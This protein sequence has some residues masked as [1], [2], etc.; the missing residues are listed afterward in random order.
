MKRQEVDMSK[1]SPMM[2]HYLEIK[3]K[4]PDTII[5]YRLGDFYEMF[6][7][8]A[9]L[10]SHELELTLTGRN[11]GLE[12]RVPM[13]GIPYHAYSSY[14][15]KLINRGYKVAICEQLEDPK[16]AKG[17]VDRDVIQVITRG[18]LMDNL[19][20]EKDNNYLA[21][22]YDYGY[23]YSLTYADISTWSTVK[24]RVLIRVLKKLLLM[25]LLIE[26]LFIILKRNIIF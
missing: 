20:S 3:E 11:A 1:V 19:V 26:R 18:T 9:E 8:D 14:V 15:T 5:F 25:I 10:V 21:S 24:E 23:S 22:I 12:E 17:I 13:C 16:L 4:Y 6:F 2:V 7:E